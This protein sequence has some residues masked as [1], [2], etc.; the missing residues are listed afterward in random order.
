MDKKYTAEEA[1]ALIKAHEER[2]ARHIIEIAETMRGGMS[3]EYDQ[4]FIN[5]IAKVEQEYNLT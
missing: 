4:A 2:T 5:L 3:S 1:E